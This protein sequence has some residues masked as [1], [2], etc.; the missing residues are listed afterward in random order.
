MWNK[1]LL[2]H[3][4]FGFI[5]SSQSKI[6]PIHA[7]HNFVL[8]YPDNFIVYASVSTDYESLVFVLAVQGIRQVLFS[9]T[10]TDANADKYLR[11][12][13]SKFIQVQTLIFLVA[14][15]KQ[16]HNVNWLLT[17][18]SFIKT[19]LLVPD[20]IVIFIDDCQNKISSTDG[21][22]KY[23]EWFLPATWDVKPAIKIEISLCSAVPALLC[24]AHCKTGHLSQNLPNTFPNTNPIL[25]NNV[26][27]AE[28][29]KQYYK[30][31]VNQKLA[32]SLA[33]V[34]NEIYEGSISKQFDRD[35][36]YAQRNYK[37]LVK[38]LHCFA[39]QM[40]VIE[41]SKICNI[42][43]TKFPT[44]NVYN[45]VQ[46]VK[47]AQLEYSI[48]TLSLQY[49]VGI[50]Y[51]YCAFGKGE[52]NG[53]LIDYCVWIA[54]FSVTGWLFLIFCWSLCVLSFTFIKGTDCFR[55][56]ISQFFFMTRIASKHLSNWQLKL[57]LLFVVGILYVW[58]LYE[59]DL[60][61]EVAVRDEMKPFSRL[62]DLDRNGYVRIRTSKLGNANYLERI[63]KK[64]AWTHF[65]K[66]DSWHLP[67]YKVIAQICEKQPEIILIAFV[68]WRQIKWFRGGWL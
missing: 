35:I 32:A 14:P 58:N 34:P 59:T 48:Y 66:W 41:L 45:I 47:V 6:Y 52:N 60:T 39:K 53:Y 7:I 61:G 3:L 55:T 12:G 5:S 38:A 57:N 16:V 17:D 63:N 21:A 25:H 20:T 24:G 50:R 42:S 8:K 23:L 15:P 22:L 43:L 54:P 13:M 4:F 49:Y 9:P 68:C 29:H 37:L 44:N 27:V 62:A 40:L 64:I 31:G 56:F 46:D 33:W 2:V 10:S 26:L 36:A 11:N 67:T 51:Y 18:Y 19:Y 65:T 28:I 1:V 30:R